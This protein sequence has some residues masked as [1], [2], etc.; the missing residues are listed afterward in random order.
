LRPKPFKFPDNWIFVKG[1]KEAM[2]QKWNKYQV[3]G[4][5]MHIMKVK[6]KMVIKLWN[7]ENLVDEIK[8]R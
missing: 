7:R 3:Q 6:N 4:N 5:S 8:S 2:K 1:F